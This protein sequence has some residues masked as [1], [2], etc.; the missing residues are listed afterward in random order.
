MTSNPAPSLRIR[1]GESL[2]T[3]SAAMRRFIYR[4]LDRFHVGDDAFHLLLATIIGALAGLG[5]V[6]FLLLIRFFGKLFFGG[7]LPAMG[8]NQYLVFLLPLL[9]GLLIGPL[10]RRF[11]AEAKGDGVPGAM[12]TIA[13]RGGIIRPRTVGLRT[14]TAA[15]TIG[16]GGSV[17]RE[18]PI[19]Q[20]G[21]AIGSAVGQFL[22]V[23]ASRMRVFVACGAAGG[24]AAV[25][26]APIG[27]VFFSLEVLLGD[28][29][30]AT[31]APIVIASVISTAVSRLLLGN[32]LIFQVPPYTLSGFQDLVISAVLGAFCGL[33]AIFFMRALES[34]E[35]QFS[36]SRIPLWARAAVGGGVTGL[37]AIFFPQVLGTDTTT[38]DAALRGSLPWFLLLLI[39]YL[40]IVATSFSLG[41]GGSGGVLGPA[42]FI[43][44]ILGAFVGTV[45]NAWFPGQVGFIGGYALIG[46]AAFLAPVIGGPITSILILFE[47]AGN[48]A[49]ILPLLV[50]VVSAMLV[51]HRFSRYSLYTRKLH[52][53]GIDL[54]AGREESI[55]KQVQVRDV[56]RGE[57]HSVLPS[58]SFGSLAASF[59][60][61]KIDYLYLTGQEGNLMGVVSLTDLR[62]FLKEENLWDLVCAQ[63][64]A[65][66]DPVAAMPSE[67]LL[68]ALNKFAYRNVAQL[69]VVSDPHTRKLIGVVR[70]SD[71]LEGYRRIVLRK[72]EPPSDEGR[73]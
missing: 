8:S 69:P 22:K 7:I 4:S 20:I 5:A 47:M 57:F 65:T 12:E 32:V 70:R 54:V 46:M 62:P 33:A 72:R 40:K 37:I 39:G 73:R 48:Y 13:L 34:A 64:V 63:D 6:A 53:K 2:H 15:V 31:F 66:P 25:F 61:S 35:E 58:E 14:L 28:F 42:V 36:S 71:L 55:L 41:S 24:I 56:M 38:L 51:A 27:G 9:G 26:N 68:D 49:I 43:G 52:E 17:G 10:I 19:A 44:G 59:F 11:P 21:A 18:A 23:S 45:A 50:A 1:L 30:A 60:N 16:S 3:G 29:A 67:S